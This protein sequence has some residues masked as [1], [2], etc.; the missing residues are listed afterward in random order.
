MRRALAPWPAAQSA[1]SRPR[2]ILL[3]A[4]RVSDSSYAPLSRRI[5]LG[6]VLFALVGWTGCVPPRPP[7]PPLSRDVVIELV[8]AQ[9][10]TFRSVKDG[11]IA[12]N[13]TTTEDGKVRSLPSLGGGIGFN[14]ELPGLYLVATKVT[15]T[16]FT[17]R[18]RGQQFWLALPRTNELVIGGPP[19]YAK[20]PWLIRPDEVQGFFADPEWL[21]LTWAGTTMTVEEDN[22]RFDI[23]TAGI[24][25]RQ[26]LVG[27]RLVV[28]RSVRRYDALQRLETEIDLADYELSDGALFPR[29]L[30]VDRPLNGVKVELE[31]SDPKLNVDFPAKTFLPPDLPGWKV[32]D[33]DHE[34]ISAVKGFE[35]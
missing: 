15:K 1:P 17:L 12:L 4:L 16:I 3:E 34:P 32:I 22:Y 27:R 9:S 23:F 19:A 10:G 24:L 18:A 5:F 2:G 6:I 29:R 7:P 33:L 20:L 14:A 30:T 28:L 8:R 25:R 11:D 21:G 31:L 35:E 13:I 26:V